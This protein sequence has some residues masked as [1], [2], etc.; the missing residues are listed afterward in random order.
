MI[1]WAKTTPPYLRTIPARGRETTRL[2][3]PSPLYLRPEDRSRTGIWSRRRSKVLGL[4]SA[5]EDLQLG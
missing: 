1:D 4:A 5:T 3:L 2:A